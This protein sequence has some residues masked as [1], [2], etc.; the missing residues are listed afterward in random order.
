MKTKTRQTQDFQPQHDEIALRAYQI[1][2][3]CGR[4]SGDEWAHWYKAEAELQFRPPGNASHFPRI[5]PKTS[6]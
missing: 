2:E 5:D 6:V 3:A 1:W 4:P